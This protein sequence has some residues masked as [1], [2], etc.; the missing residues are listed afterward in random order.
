MHDTS[1]Q[2]LYSLY[3]FDSFLKGKILEFTRS[4]EDMFLGSLAYNMEIEYKKTINQY[5]TKKIYKH[6]LGFKD[7]IND[8]NYHLYEFEP[9]WD[10]FFSDKSKITMNDEIKLWESLN[11]NDFLR[12]NSQQNNIFKDKRNA[13]RFST[14]E[15]NYIKNKFSCTEVKKMY[16]RYY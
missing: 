10:E 8:K 11:N 1:V 15:I 3:K 14:D 2:N 12:K 6:N 9:L 13:K 7:K 4:F 16:R 5:K